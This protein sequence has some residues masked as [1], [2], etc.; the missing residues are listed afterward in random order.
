MP[1]PPV[2]LPVSFWFCV[3]VG[4]AVVLIFFLH[5]LVFIPGG[6][7]LLTHSVPI[8]LL[9]FKAQFKCHSVGTIPAVS[10]VS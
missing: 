7:I 6:M 2:A 9:F 5:L 3:A 4:R 8:Y 1:I 10:P